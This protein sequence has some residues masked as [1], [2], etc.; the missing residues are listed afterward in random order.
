MQTPIGE[1]HAGALLVNC[2]VD[3]P[4][5]AM[6]SNMKQ[7]Y[8]ICSRLYC[9]DKGKTVDQCR[10]HLYEGAMHPK[11]QRLL[12]LEPR[13]APNGHHIHCLYVT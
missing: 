1:M 2:T 7:W 9:E 8:G 11:L 12:D 3:L 13:Y 10:L 5:R 6:L 4:A